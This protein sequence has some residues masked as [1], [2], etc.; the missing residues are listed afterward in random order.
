MLYTHRFILV[1]LSLFLATSNLYADSVGV[2]YWSMEDDYHL[3]PFYQYDLYKFFAVLGDAGIGS[4]G[5]DASVGFRF[6]IGATRKF[7]MRQ[8]QVLMTLR[9]IALDLRT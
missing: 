5:P 7:P 9:R 6:L 1:L 4:S 2:N 3:C 8:T